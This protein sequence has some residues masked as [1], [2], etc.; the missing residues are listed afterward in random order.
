ML[1]M[2]EMA[3]IRNF[4]DNFAEDTDDG[5]SKTTD[6][7]V[8][9]E[10]DRIET[11]IKGERNP[12][13][14]MDD[15]IELPTRK[16]MM[17]PMPTIED[18][19]SMVGSTSILPL[20]IPEEQETHG[21]IDHEHDCRSDGIFS[22]KP[23]S[24]TNLDDENEVSLDMDNSRHNYTFKLNL[25]PPLNSPIR[26]SCET[27]SDKICDD[28]DNSRHSYGLGLDLDGSSHSGNSGTNF[29]SSVRRV[30]SEEKADSPEDGLELDIDM[31]ISYHRHRS[32]GLN[33]E[34]A[35]SP[36]PNKDEDISTKRESPLCV[37]D[38]V[39]SDLVVDTTTPS[40]MKRKTKVPEIK[41]KL[42]L[43]K[44]S[45]SM[46]SFPTLRRNSSKSSKRPENIP[47]T[48]PL[49]PKP[50]KSIL[51]SASM[52]DLSSQSNRTVNSVSSDD[53]TTSSINNSP[54]SRKMKRVTSFSK[55]E[56]REYNITLGDNPGGRSGPPVSLDWKYDKNSQVVDVD[57]YEESRPPRRSRIEM[58]MGGSVRM[59][60]LMREQ[61]FSMTDMK[62]AAKSAAEVR[63]QRD[64]TVKRVIQRDAIRQTV[65]SI[66]P[67]KK[68]STST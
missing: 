49:T 42:N 47:E 65:S 59:F 61:G 55:I 57:L 9:E 37:T 22:R 62:K 39:K 18:A 66:F 32:L 12:T 68:K 40:S 25:D 50:L 46:L 19:T 30:N 36:V 26:N 44:K 28:M 13:F 45:R 54:S 15:I 38:F 51:K 6:D 31:D 4:D 43:M 24:S 20:S 52:V 17:I 21:R 10:F 23:S 48:A 64:K 2:N 3:V 16:P 7:Y 14:S 8:D 34:K 33:L 35:P 11:L 56:I 60:R 5:K 27:K 29:F 67:K 53:S 58:H 1:E 41:P 63:K